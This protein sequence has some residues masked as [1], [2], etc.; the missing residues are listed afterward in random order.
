[1]ATGG[2]RTQARSPT[3]TVPGSLAHTMAD[4]LVSVSSDTGSSSTVLVEVAGIE[5]ASSGGS[6]GLL[7]A[8]LESSL[9]GLTGPSSKPV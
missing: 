5:P 9:L 7:R 8:Q 6:T 2:G 4:L 1:M 3:P